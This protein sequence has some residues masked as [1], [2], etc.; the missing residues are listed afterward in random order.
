VWV[1]A[2]VGAVPPGAV[3]NGPLDASFVD[4]VCRVATGNALIP[5][6]LLSPWY[7]YYGDGMTEVHAADYQVLVPAG[8]TVAWTRAPAGVNPPYTL[9]TGRDTQGAPLYSCRVVRNDAGTGDLG[10]TGLGT[11]HL[12]VFSDMQSFTSDTFDVLTVY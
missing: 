1:D 5:G 12:C 9:E 11:N 2:S 3:P 8:C 7:C 10:Y 6:K 4:Y